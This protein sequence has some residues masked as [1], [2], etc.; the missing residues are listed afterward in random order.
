MLTTIDTT[1]LVTV[2]GGTVRASTTDATLQ[3]LQTLLT[4]L[5]T[6][7]QN[8]NTGFNNPTTM[9]MFALLASRP[10]VPLVNGVWY[11]LVSC[12]WAVVG[13][14]GGCFGAASSRSKTS[15]GT[16]LC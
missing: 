11:Y 12:G 9:L 14:S 5:S 10:R 6:S 13:T 15:C 4:T 16:V 8:N 3:Q 1:T 2:T 7:Q